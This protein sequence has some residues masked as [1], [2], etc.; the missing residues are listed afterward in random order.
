MT[1]TKPTTAEAAFKK[2]GYAQ[3]PDGVWMQ[4]RGE[5]FDATKSERWL[6][7]PGGYLMFRPSRPGFF[8]GAPL[9]WPVA[10]ILGSEDD[11]Q[12]ITGV[13]ENNAVYAAVTGRK[14]PASL[15]NMIQTPMRQSDSYK[16]S[17]GLHPAEHPEAFDWVWPAQAVAEIYHYAG[18]NVVKVQDYD[19]DGQPD[20]Y[21]YEAAPE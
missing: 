16:N 1:I 13:Q 20:G 9:G 4:A 6:E 11:P 10:R 14:Y 8:G 17:S 21:H 2:Y 3:A 7:V 12:I 15:I 5:E 19:K 18:E